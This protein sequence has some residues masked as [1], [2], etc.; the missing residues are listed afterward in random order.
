[1]WENSS[2]TREDSVFAF[3]IVHSRDLVAMQEMVSWSGCS[4]ACPVP[5]RSAP[6][7]SVIFDTDYN[8]N[9]GDLS[10]NYVGVKTSYRGII[11]MQNTP[12]T[13]AALGAT[14][15]TARI[16]KMEAPSRLEWISTKLHSKFVSKR[17][18]IPA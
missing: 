13:C 17:E 8:P 5:S 18:S 12:T 1:M 4:G 3:A 2:N 6:G 16:Y 15:R 14:V 10:N 7:I 9:M 11:S